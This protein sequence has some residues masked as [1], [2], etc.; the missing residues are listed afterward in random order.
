MGDISKFSKRQIWR[1]VIFLHICHLWD[2]VHTINPLCC[3]ENAVLLHFML[4]CPECECEVEQNIKYD[5]VSDQPIISLS[6]QITGES[7]QMVL[8]KSKMEYVKQCFKMTLSKCTAVTAPHLIKTMS[9]FKMLN[10]CCQH[11]LR[12]YVSSLHYSG[13]LYI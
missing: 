5:K 2:F 9:R 13:L 6:V 4:L 7:G 10:K 1:N 8:K 11:C 12:R 3:G